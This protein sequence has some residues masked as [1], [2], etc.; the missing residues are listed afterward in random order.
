[1]CVIEVYAGSK[2]YPEFV[3]GQEESCIERNLQE[4]PNPSFAKASEDSP[5]LRS[6]FKQVVDS[7]WVDPS[8]VG[9]TKQPV[10]CNNRYY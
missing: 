2:V 1:M 8:F 3:E 10:L 5:S 4:Q 9:M 7:D 6:G